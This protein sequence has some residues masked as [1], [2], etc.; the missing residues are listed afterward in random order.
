MTHFVA[1]GQEYDVLCPRCTHLGKSL[2]GT[3]LV[4]GPGPAVHLALCPGPAVV[5]VTVLSRTLLG[6]VCQHML[7]EA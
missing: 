6:L 5:S 4:D 7:V 3:A 2:A 1:V